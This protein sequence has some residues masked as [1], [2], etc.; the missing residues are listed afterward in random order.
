MKPIDKDTITIDLDETDV[1]SN[2]QPAALIQQACYTKLQIEITRDLSKPS[3]AAKSEIYPMGSGFVYFIDGTRGA[4]KSTFLTTTYVELANGKPLPG[5]PAGNPVTL[6]RLAY[7]DP[8]CIERSEII[9]LPILKALKQL[10]EKASS[11]YSQKD[12]D[13]RCQGSCRIFMG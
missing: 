8:S 2:V 13:G 5:G 10:V 4:G 7:I 6:G 9:L 11:S 12:E 3:K 1:N